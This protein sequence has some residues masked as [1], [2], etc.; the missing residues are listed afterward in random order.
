VTVAVRQ[1]IRSA[2]AALLLVAALLGGQAL[3]DS[4]VVQGTTGGAG[5]TVG[6]AGFA[7]LTGLRRFAAL[8]LWARLD[9]QFHGYYS[10]MPI[11]DQLFLLPNMR[12]V[13]ML[14]PQFI[15]AYYTAPWILMDN[16]R[17]SDALAV[18][19]EGVEANPRSGQLHA[20]YAQMLYL[21][22]KDL[23]GA[24]EQ[25]DLAMR[26]D[27]LWADGTEQWQAMMSI[28]DIYNKA[29]LPERA[30]RAIAI[31]RQIETDLG[32]APGYRDEDEQ[33]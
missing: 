19:R 32:S 22:T 2:S 25:S 26:D 17:L 24:V 21:K 30:A 29:K 1:R 28:K 5:A 31:A 16:D 18:A 27:A 8:L 13:T 15:Q 7:Y 10:G 23:S 33:F 11:K 9:T 4:S 6:R 3:A 20:S 12:L 14:D